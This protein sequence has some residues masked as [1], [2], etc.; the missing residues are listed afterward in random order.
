MRNLSLAVAAVAVA[1][2]LPAPGSAAPPAV[3]L[4]ART[5]GDLADLCTANP[6]DALGAVR[7]GFCHGFAQGAI[8][9]AFRRSGD[10]KPFCFPTPTPSRN[11]T[12]AEF[13]NW[14]RAQ[15]E[16]R[17]LPVIEGLFQFMAERFP[18]KP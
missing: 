17:T 14:V 9:D 6:E 18:C 4:Q 5:A 10:K 1:L 7:A 13:A 8:D 2:L 16:R 15:P 12:L 11:A 3:N